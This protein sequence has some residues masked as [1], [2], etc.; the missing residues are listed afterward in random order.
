MQNTQML[1]NVV[2]A[3]HTK[4][5]WLSKGVC[6]CKV[7]SHKSTLIIHHA[8]MVI[9]NGHTV[10]LGMF[11]FVWPQNKRLL[12]AETLYCTY[13]AYTGCPKK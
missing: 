9:Q 5:L 2:F 6:K 8:R 12:A 13:S 1:S 7:C 4:Q 11:L 3:N 10:L